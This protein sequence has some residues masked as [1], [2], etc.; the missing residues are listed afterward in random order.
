MILTVDD[1]F[2]L[3]AIADSGQCFRWERLDTGAYRVFHGANCLRVSALGGGRFETDCGTAEFDAV[4]RDYFDLDEDYRAIR[5][6]ID[7][8][9]D[10]F[11]FAASEGERGIRILR[12]DP[13]EALVCFLISQNKNIPAI[14]RSVALLAEA[15][16]E[17][18]RDRAGEPFYAFPGPEAVAA[19]DG[20][21]LRRCGLGYRCAYVHAAAE[22]VRTGAVDLERLRLAG[23]ETATA[24]LTGLYGVGAKVA[25]CVSLFGLHHLNAFPKDVWIRRVLAQAYPDG[26]PFGKYAPYNGVYQQYLFAWSRSLAGKREGADGPVR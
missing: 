19:L 17:R 8:E 4:W 25:G 9:A 11:L 20:E 10:P 12:Q 7:P 5:A 1:D 24:A 13:W 23:E 22:A 14:R 6:R 15:A 18:R 16:G 26:Y 3:D 2:D 21:T